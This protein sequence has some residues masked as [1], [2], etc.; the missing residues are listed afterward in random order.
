MEKR[1][2]PYGRQ[3]INDEDIQAVVE[4]LRSDWLTQGPAVERFEQAVAD[5]CGARYAVAVANGTAALHLAALAAGFGPEDE[6]VTSPITFVASANCLAYVGARPVFADIDPG[7]YCLDPARIRE[8]LT[9]ATRGLIPVHFSGQPCDMRAI[10]DLASEHG[11]LVI[12]DAAHAIG[13][14]YQVDGRDYKV[15]S[16]AHSDLCIFSFHPVK[17]VT[18]GEG[19]MVLTNNEELH[20]KL[21]LLR[22]H[23]ITRD[24]DMLTRND[25][26]W[27]YEQHALGF[28]YR[29]TDIQ[30]ALGLSQLGRLDRFVVRR[31]EIAETYNQAFSA[32]KELILAQEVSGSR[33]SRHLYLLGFRTLQ[34]RRVFDLLR[35]RGVGVNV[36]YIPVHLQPYYRDR[37]GFR[38]GD[39]PEAERYYSRTLTLPLFPGMSDS[40][41]RYVIQSVLEVVE[42]L[43]P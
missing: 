43:E 16:C 40:D 1:F 12:E 42:E 9:S 35:E 38:T 10:A 24:P 36:H 23:G 30:C 28:N 32:H 14:S 11:L 5:Y 31:R 22:T 18:T 13:A 41:V 2:I 3:Q 4:V 7:T 26:P 6:V 21:L 27:Y 39:C 20:R 15:G 17:H 29:I 34:R 25:G 37:Y 8:K 33:S 19:G